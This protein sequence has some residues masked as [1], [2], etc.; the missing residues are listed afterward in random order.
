MLHKTNN[1]QT[2]LE[3]RGKIIT[4]DLFNT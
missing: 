3:M 1:R 4:A 2:V